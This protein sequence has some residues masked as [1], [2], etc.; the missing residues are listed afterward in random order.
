MGTFDKNCT[1]I[2]DLGPYNFIRAVFTECFYGLRLSQIYD[3]RTNRWCWHSTNW[4]GIHNKLISHVS[5]G[6]ITYYNS[7]VSVS[8]NSY[9]ILIKLSK[10]CLSQVKATTSSTFIQRDHKH[11]KNKIF[12]SNL[13]ENIIFT[14]WYQSRVSLAENALWNIIPGNILNSISTPYCRT[15]AQ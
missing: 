2:I 11:S 9:K 4:S 14:R 7:I 6:V 12:K 5:V 10:P 15:G 13:E 3:D 1:H 8:N